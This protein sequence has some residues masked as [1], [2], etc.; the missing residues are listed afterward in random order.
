[1]TKIIP[2]VLERELG[3]VQRQINKLESFT[4]VVHLDVCDGVFVPTVSFHDPGQLKLLQTAVSFEVHLMV[5]HPEPVL[6]DWLT[7]GRVKRVY[8]QAEAGDD[9]ENVLKE[10]RQM[11][12]E[13]GLAINMETGIE[14]VDRYLTEGLVD[15]LLLLA[16]KPGRQGQ[17]HDA[18]VAEK[19]KEVKKKYPSV[20]VGVDGG[21][22]DLTAVPLVKAGADF[23]VVGSYLAR[24][25]EPK[26]AFASLKKVAE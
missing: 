20:K 14:V 13:A 10:I 25:T 16:V 1:M 11:G 24:A 12:K 26:L 5:S 15:Y 17:E 2:A 9:L 21:I 18:T 22:N 8:V 23:L 3:D 19:V 4:H 6:H 7:A